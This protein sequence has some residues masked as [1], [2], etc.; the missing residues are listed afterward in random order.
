M[1]VTE[2]G[3][4]AFFLQVNRNKR[5]LT[6]EIDNPEG[7]E[8]LHKL[9]RTADVVIANMPPRVLKGLGIDYDSLRLDQARHHPHGVFGLRQPSRG[10]RP[11]R[12]RRR[13]PGHERRRV[14]DRHCRT[15]R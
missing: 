1:P 5:S 6:L 11:R 10:Q 13:R 8:V 12:L 9:V 15:I 2:H 4:G 14:H 7:K 3:E